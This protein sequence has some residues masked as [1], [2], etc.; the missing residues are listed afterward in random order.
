MP[1]AR[2]GL[3]V[4]SNDEPVAFVPCN[5]AIQLNVALKFIG[6]S[7]SQ[8]TAESHLSYFEALVKKYPQI[9]R[10]HLLIC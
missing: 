1:F 2:D 5:L 4:S 9:I 10:L 3:I 8:E 6:T 7:Q